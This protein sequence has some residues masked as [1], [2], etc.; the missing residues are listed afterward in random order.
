M[1]LRTVGTAAT[2][3]LDGI[4]WSQDP[5]IL[6]R[7]DVAALIQLI[8][9]DLTVGTPVAQVSGVGGLE[10]SAGKLWVP[11]RGSLIIYPGD[12]IAVDT[13]GGVIHITARAAAAADWVIS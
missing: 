6:S 12:V 10:Q 9:D 11:N 3:S 1:A 5:A 4:V 8:K 2:T 13:T 7:A